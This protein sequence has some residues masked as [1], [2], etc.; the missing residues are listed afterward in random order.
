MDRLIGVAVLAALNA[1][2]AW[3]YSRLP[4]GPDEGMWMLTGWTGARYG[5]DY[6]DCKP[7]GVHLWMALLARLTG[8]RVGAAKFLHHLTVG[9]LAIAAYLLSGQLATGLM[10]TA[11]LQSA[12]LYAYQSWTDALGASLLLVAVL[13]PP[14]WMPAV[15]VVAVLFNVK[16][17]VP[18]AVWV[19]LTPAT[20]LPAALTGA[21]VAVIAGGLWMVR[22][23][24]LERV[25]FASVEVPRRMTILRQSQLRH[26]FV[27][28]PQHLGVGLLLVTT[29]VVLTLGVN[30][31]W[32][33]ALVAG[34]YVAFNS[35]GGVWRPNHWLPLAVVAAATP[36]LPASLAVLAAEW[37]SM[38]A[39]TVN[40]WAVTYPELAPM[41]E[42]ARALGERLREEEGA[43]WVNTF[44]TQIY[45]YAGKRPVYDVE[46][47]EIRDVT[48]ERR[49]ARDK[50]LRLEP[51]ATIVVGPGSWSGHPHNYRPVFQSGLF[52]VWQ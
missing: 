44:N 31:D 20:W 35:W 28:W 6:V 42:Q 25:W 39:Y 33:L 40:A 30:A 36:T 24:W 51:P 46:Q 22:R 34:S 7:P 21:G 26:V 32:R 4:I 27:Q 2:V 38:R 14:A 9:A 49:P 12:W 17:A 41:L 11:L 13:A 16:M 19:L 3:R 29:S 50:R 8:R 15:L 45:V 43:L 52:E 47:L 48:P 1:W 10:A 18:G 37:V 5:V 23:D